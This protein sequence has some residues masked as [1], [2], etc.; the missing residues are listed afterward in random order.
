MLAHCASLKSLAYPVC[1]CD[2]WRH[3]CRLHSNC[4][5]FSVYPTGVFPSLCIKCLINKRRLILT[6]NII[7]VTVDCLRADHTGFGGY[8]SGI[9]PFLDQLASESIVFENA[10]AAGIP[11][12]Y[13]FPV[14]LASRYPLAFGR[15][16]MGLVKDEPTFVSELH[17]S[18]FQTAALIAGNPYLSRHFHYDQNF[19]LFDD[20][21][22]FQHIADAPPKKYESTPG[23][24]HQSVK[25]RANQII[26]SLAG[27][28]QLTQ[29]F[30][31]ELY[32]RYSSSEM[33]RIHDGN[34]AA[35]RRYPPADV[36]MDKAIA[37]MRRAA[38]Q[39]VFLWVHLMDPH[40]PYFPPRQALE[41]I[42]RNDLDVRQMVYLNAL[43][44]RDD[45]GR[46]HRARYLNDMLTLYDG[47]IHWVDTQVRRLVDASIE[48]GIWDNTVLVLAGD[49]GEEFLEHGGHYHYP[50]K[51]SQELIHVPLLIRQP[52]SN[53]PIRLSTPF[54]LIHLA[55]TL[56][57]MQNIKLPVEFVGRS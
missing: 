17:D 7:L 11:T 51:L 18:G 9:T 45:I 32:L 14:L 24:N 48:L 39:R 36:V 37:W 12:Y 44:S 5:R 10:I 56:L 54:S 23:V 1:L 31:R 42:G 49:H 43:W 19:D 34:L 41:A 27:R 38:G 35:F 16:F 3:S 26:R 40:Y 21:S 33:V 22:D 15:D 53:L 4:L 6:T 29:A 8:R 2:T 13:S 28:T 25:A 20:F 50:E 57:D 30:Y 46:N 55:P 52:T 47:G